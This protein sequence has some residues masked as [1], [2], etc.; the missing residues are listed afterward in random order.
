MQVPLSYLVNTAYPELT[1]GW[2]LNA[3]LYPFNIVLIWLIGKKI[4]G[5]PAVW[6][7]I[8]AAINPWTIEM[9]TQPIVE[10]S[11]LFF[12][13][14][15]F[16]FI[17]RRS[18]WAYL[19]AMMASMMRY[20][21][22]L[23]IF[24][25]LAMDMIYTEN[26]KQ[27]VYSFLYAAV[28]SVPIGLWILA[29]VIDSLAGGNI[30]YAA[31]ITAGRSEG[32]FVFFEYI[33]M[34]WEAVFQ[35]LF[36]LDPAVSEKS[37]SHLYILNR[38]IAAVLIVL[39]IIYSF[40]KRNWYILAMLMFLLPYLVIHALQGSILQ[41]HIVAIGWMVLIICVYG[42][43]TIWALINKDRR[44]PK[45]VVVSL[46]VFFLVVVLIWLLQ[47]VEYL[48]KSKNISPNSV[49]VPYFAMLA[50]GFIFVLYRFAY[51]LKFFM[52]HLCV[53]ILMFLI[54]TCNQLT[55]ALVMETGQDDIEFKM[56]AQWYVAN[57]EPGEKMITT[58]SNLLSIFVPKYE[59]N[60]VHISSMQAENANDFIIECYEKNITYVAWDS[61]L[62]LLPKDTHFKRWNLDRIVFLV[63][64]QDVGPYEFVTQLEA[65]QRR[66]IHV[67]KLKDLSEV[68]IQ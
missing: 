30:P 32:K 25:A 20:E 34:T 53:T 16:Y 19:F 22:A 38:I 5:K 59:D 29:I 1:A 28:A 6:V 15:S 64:P 12:I 27:R 42:L 8:I 56:L 23:M 61:R 66:Y 7:A 18:K 57:A 10:I 49:Y 24:I 26:K 21:G 51:K 68:L 41:R 31:D 13:L 43:Q 60:F 37:F 47:L 11:L 9:L 44:F 35:H 46:Q 62:G 40:I 45:P 52:P 39:G 65:S 58:M 48:P 2:L 54:I 17:S 55:L 33:E 67:F 36:S 4:I 63:K 50:A 14:L 3:I